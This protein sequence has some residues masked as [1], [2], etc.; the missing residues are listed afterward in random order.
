MKRELTNKQQETLEKRLN[1]LISKREKLKEI[2]N[3]HQWEEAHRIISFSLAQEESFREE[4]KNY[5]DILIDGLRRAKR[6]M[7]STRDLMLKNKKNKAADTFWGGL[8]YLLLDYDN[9]IRM[10]EYKVNLKQFFAGNN[11]EI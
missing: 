1:F 5:N 3:I 2:I 10:I 11:N 8:E 6:E 7:D 9:V 4:H